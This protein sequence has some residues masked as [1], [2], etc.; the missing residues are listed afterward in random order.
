MLLIVLVNDYTATE[1]LR[2]YHG[3]GAFLTD[4]KRCRMDT[5]VLWVKGIWL[6]DSWCDGSLFNL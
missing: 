6:L 4:N 1:K 2:V 3:Y 5:G